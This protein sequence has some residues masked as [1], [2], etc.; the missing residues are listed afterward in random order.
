MIKADDNYA[1]AFEFVPDC[2]KTPE[3]RDKAVNTYPSTI[4]FVPECYKT[5]KMCDAVITGVFLYLILLL[6]SVNCKYCVTELFAKILLYKYIAPIDIKLKKR[7]MKLLM[8][9][10]E[11]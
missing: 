11:H 10:W 2:F 8:I 6:I 7:V 5:R 3:I 4:K 1:H 9:V